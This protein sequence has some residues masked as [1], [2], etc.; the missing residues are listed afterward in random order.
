MHRSLTYWRIEFDR[1]DYWLCHLVTAIFGARLTSTSSLRR[2][3]V[4][5]QTFCISS[6]HRFDGSL[7]GCRLSHR[8]TVPTWLLRAGSRLHPIAAGLSLFLHGGARGA[9]FLHRYFPLSVVVG[10][11]IVAVSFVVLPAVKASLKGASPSVI[12]WSLSF[13]LAAMNL[14]MFLRI[15]HHLKWLS[16]RGLGIANG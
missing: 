14:V 7:T 9:H 15:G 11:K 5:R 16:R 6:H 1:L 12:G 10:W 4:G 3:D 8:P 13:A 2:A